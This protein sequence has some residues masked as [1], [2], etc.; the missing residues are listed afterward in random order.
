MDYLRL[1]REML[2]KEDAEF[3]EGQLEAIERVL[4]GKRTL[5]VERTGWGKSIVYFLATRLLRDMGKGMTLIVS[6]L[7]SLMNDQIQ[8]AEQMGI[9][10]RTISSYNED[11]HD[12][13]Y[14]Q[15]SRENEVDALL[16]S[17][18]RLANPRF[19]ELLLNLTDSIGFFVV[20][21]AHC[22]SD[23][24]HDFRPDYRR[25]VEIINNL[26]SDIP[27]LATT[28][29]ANNRVVE[30][31]QEQI[32][33]LE[34]IRGTLL[35]ESLALQTIKMN[36]FAEKLAWIGKNID[37]F[38]G[39]GIIYCNTV[40]HAELVD[41]YLRSIGKR[42]AVYTGKL[43]AEERDEVIEGFKGTED[44]PA[45][46]DTI[47]ATTALGMGF[48]MPDLKYVIHF[49][50]PGNVI[51]YYQQIGRAGREIDTAYAV[52]LYN[53]KDD[54]VNR[55]FIDR[56]FPEDNLMDEI[57]QATVTNQ[58]TGMSM[59]EYE[60][61]VNAK[62]SDIKGALKFLEVEGDLYKEGNK[63]YK[64]PRPWKV[65]H[66]R[67]ERITAR[68]YMEL[69]QLNEF[70]QTDRCYMEYI[71]KLLDDES[72]CKCGKCSNCIGR[73]ILDFEEV[74]M[75]E[76]EA[77]EEFIHR[78]TD[79]IL[80]RRKWPNVS[81][82]KQ[83]LSISNSNIPAEYQ[84]GEG[85]CLSRYGNEG[86]GAKV[87]RGKYR[88]GSF[89]DELVEASVDLL[90]R[91]IQDNSITWIAY[92]PSLNHPELVRSFAERLS[93]KLGIPCKNALVKTEPGRQQKEYNNSFFQFLN[94]YNTFDVNENEI[95]DGNVL[96]VDDMVDSRWTL[97]VCGY[98][99]MKKGS[100]RVYPF[101]LANTSGNRSE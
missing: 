1:L 34:V 7:I 6:P 39:S 87:Q 62:Q 72:A 36:T 74:T 97:T 48:D 8:H 94:A 45:C 11:M 81:E 13:I 25:I 47:V 52:L 100:G 89:S 70:V 30:D 78:D 84:L 23:W 73:D 5:V 64:T 50:K 85:V 83:L 41:R 4:A 9:K 33:G 55:F 99:L 44:T 56:A 68:R 61:Y 54:E 96:L 14:D 24:G 63:Y 51:S 42:T 29:T 76:A 59:M 65:D 10:V 15:I 79:V 26:P 71:A 57:I 35:R 28:A 16:I 32:A 12:E 67:A 21:E 18:E 2:G 80:P 75:E 31:V 92:I 49:E 90:R 93:S 91:F 19:R 95:Y 53:E 3:R 88:D 58:D 98:K 46:T 60:Y 40:A 20:D 82:V 43:N 22:I 17:P 27:I 69:D 86:Y 37:K 66:E 77:A 38:G 101:A